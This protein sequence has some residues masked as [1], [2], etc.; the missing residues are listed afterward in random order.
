MPPSLMPTPLP[1]VDHRRTPLFSLLSPFSP[2]QRCRPRRRPPLFAGQLRPEPMPLPSL[3]PCPGHCAGAAVRVL[4]VACRASADHRP[5]PPRRVPRCTP[6]LAVDPRWTPAPAHM[7]LALALVPPPLPA[8]N[9]RPALPPYPFHHI[10]HRRPVSRLAT[11][12]RRPYAIADELPRRTLSRRCPCATIRWPGKLDGSCLRVKPE[13]PSF[14]V[15]T[16]DRS[17]R[18][19]PSDLTGEPPSLPRVPRLA[20]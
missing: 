8:I 16:V 3:C 5:P 18:L 17:R 12:R 4:A 7:S 9:S 2:R 11:A 13:P 20:K 10:R 1:R 14:V 19:P 15:P 6:L